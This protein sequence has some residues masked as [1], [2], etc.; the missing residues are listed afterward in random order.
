ME[1]NRNIR[2]SKVLKEINISLNRA[3]DF[4]KNK[5]INIEHSPNAKISE[6]EFQVL[7]KQFDNKKIPD[8]IFKLEN[9][10]G[11]ILREVD[12]EFSF[13]WDFKCTFL[14]NE[15]NEVIG[16]NL[17]NKSIDNISFLSHFK[18]L[19]FLDISFNEILDFSPL[20]ELKKIEKISLDNTNIKS[21]SSISD[22]EFLKHLSIAQNHLDDYEEVSRFNELE[23]LCLQSNKLDSI[24]FLKSNN[25]IKFL[26]LSFNEIED[27]SKL[28]KYFSLEILLLNAN[29]IKDFNFLASLNNL[30]RLEIGAC[31]INDISFLK[32][33]K[34]NALSIGENPIEEYTILKTLENLE[35]LR[36]THSNLIDV[37]FIQDLKSLVYLHLRDNKIEKISYLKNLHNLRFVDVSK[38]NIYDIEEFEFILNKSDLFI[39]ANSNPCFE[40][41]NIILNR[42]INHYSIVVNEL[43]KREDNQ[44]NGQIPEKI[45]LLGNHKSGKSSLLHYLQNGDLDFKEDSTHILKIENYPF[46]YQKLPK[47]IIYDFGGQDFYHGIYNA[48]LTVNSITLLLW[49][50][51]TNKN[52]LSLDSNKKQN[53]NY[54]VDYWLGQRNKKR[55][56]SVFMSNFLLIQT[57][58]D[59]PKSKRKSYLNEC[60]SDG[61]FYLSLEKESKYPNKNNI[62]HKNLELLKLTLDQIIFNNQLLKNSSR[63]ISFHTYNLLTYIL[64]AEETHEPIQKSSLKQYYSVDSDERFDTEI[65][66]LHLQG[67]I[68]KHNDNVWLKPMKL[69]SYFHEKILER[70]L[71]GKGV[72]GKTQFENTISKPIKDLLIDQKVIFYDNTD[73]QYIIPNYLPLTSEDEKIY[74][75]LTFDHNES[76][77]ILKF[78]NFIPFGLINQLVCYYGKNEGV[79]YYWRDQLIFK[80][81]DS[82]FRVL[83]KLDY[84]N[85]EISVSVKS[86]ELNISTSETE[87]NVFSD[88]LDLYWGNKPFEISIDNL[89]NGKLETSVGYIG[90]EFIN[91]YISPE[92]MFLSVDGKTFVNHKI[93]EDEN[94]TKLKINSYTLT[95]ERELD[96]SNVVEQSS[97]VYKNFTNNKQIK[98]M[99]KIFVSYSNEDHYYKDLLMKNLKPLTQFQLLKPWSCEDMTSGN[100]NEQIQKEL[101]EADIV[102]FMM[103]LNFIT[104]DY[105]LKEEVF[106]TFEEIKI[107]PNKKIIC[108]LVKNF[109]WQY[110]NKF[111][112]LTNLGEDD[113]TRLQE[114]NTLTELASKQFIPYFV[115]DKGTV[116]EKRYLKPLNKW[117]YEEDAYIEIVRNITQNLEE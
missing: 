73:K 23:H 42:N 72:I 115:E 48:F 74:E 8:E 63:K 9:R 52:Y 21:L 32:D 30:S 93:L 106:K 28:E 27:V 114:A 117:E 76:N 16:L 100:W 2:I 110:F 79:K 19:L 61:E 80:T 54:N 65:E 69:A 99:K 18:D 64:K 81:N 116:N 33:L 101:K 71:I 1:E 50:S 103:S 12:S 102:I 111:K 24:A 10:L 59:N 17:C 84:S 53:I 49:N 45:L 78:K 15:R 25:K 34:I 98:E 109:S 90:K 96:F 82:R 26:D 104:S 68:L 89:V 31:H 51:Q 108:V 112:S 91:M 87:R 92:D 56:D 13:G 14:L 95:K 67:L 57:H 7:F 37:S 3:I 35:E 44:V 43:K 70:D 62:K 58:S 6:N 38:N 77:F 107:N 83:I 75:L 86:I 113:F 4:L 47:A 85:L 20:K 29:N 46:K 36:I 5:G 94:K 97:G 105:I 60:N 22:F 39:Y 55:L 41:N 40:E 88:I 66:Q 11:Y